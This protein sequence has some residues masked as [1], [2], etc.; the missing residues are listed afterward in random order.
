M[1]SYSP[2]GAKRIANLTGLKLQEL[3]DRQSLRFCGELDVLGN[4]RSVSA[5]PSVPIGMN[6]ATIF[7]IRG[8]SE[9]VVGT[10]RIA[11]KPTANVSFWGYLQFRTITS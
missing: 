8:Q 10:S 3:K 7:H 1:A 4:D 2:F 9:S 11:D 6:V 5:H